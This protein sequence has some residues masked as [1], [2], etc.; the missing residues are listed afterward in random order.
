[1]KKLFVIA[2]AGM[3]FASC[4][5]S[6][7]NN[8]NPDGDKPSSIRGVL[9]AGGDRSFKAVV[10]YRGH[11]DTLNVA[12]GTANSVDG[13][14]LDFSYVVGELISVKPIGA[15]GNISVNVYKDG[16]LKDN[17]GQSHNRAELFTDIV[18]TLK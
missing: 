11:V 6:S 16:T 5:K 8:I 13:A 1:M 15:V 17:Y 10:S 4:S 3:V 7:D 9:K 14:S 12:V 18:I 2:I